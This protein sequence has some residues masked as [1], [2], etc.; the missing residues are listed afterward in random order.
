MLNEQFLSVF[1]HN[2]KMNVPDKGQSPLPQ[3]YTTRSQVIS[4]VGVETQPLSWNPVKLCRLIQTIENCC[5]IIG[6]ST[7][8]LV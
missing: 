5:T 6:T 7:Y 2:G 3:I 8:F 1:T 4:T